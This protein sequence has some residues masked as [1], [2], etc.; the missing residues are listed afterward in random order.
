MF[1]VALSVT[2]PPPLTR[3]TS[4]LSHDDASDDTATSNPHWSVPPT[5]T[6]PEPVPS[7]SNVTAVGVGS[8]E[9]DVADCVTD[10]VLVPIVTV[11]IRSAPVFAVA[12]SV[13]VPP[14]ST[15]ATSALSHDAAPLD[16]DTAWLQWSEPPT[17]TPP[18]PVP[19][20]PNVTLVGV[21]PGAL[22]HAAADC[23]TDT[24]LVPIVTV[25]VRSPPVF[26]VA[27]SVT[28][29]PPSASVTSALSHD[30]PLDTDTA[31]LQWSEPPTSTPPSP[32][33]S[34][35]KVTDVGVKLGAAR[36]P[37]RRLRHRHRARADRHRP[38]ALA[39][40][41]RRHSSPIT[42]PPPDTDDEPTEIQSRLSLTLKLH[43]DEPPAV[44]DL[45]PEPLPKLRD[46]V[47]PDDEQPDDCVMLTLLPPIVTVPVRRGPSLAVTD[48]DTEPPPDTDDEPT[49]IQLRLSLT[50]KLHDD[51][52]PAVADLL[53]EPLPKLRDDVVPDDEQP[54]DCVML[55][56]L[57]PIVTV[58]VR[59]G[60]SLAVT[61]TDTEPPPDT[62]DEPTL[63]QLRLS[64]TL[65]LH[66]DE[67]PAV[68]DLL[69]E[70]LPK[71]RDDVVPD[72]EQPDDCVMLTLLP[73]IVTV[74]VRR[75][76][77]LAVTDTDTEPPPDTDDEPTLI[78]LRLSL[79]LKLHDDEP[80]AVADLLPEPLP[81]LRDDVVPDDEQPD[82][83]VMLT[84][85][86]PIVTVPVRRG[87]SLAVTDTD[88]EPPPDT[89]D[90]PTLIQLRLS[91][92]LKLH[93]DEPPAVA[94]LLPEPLP[95]LRDDVVPDDEQPDA[96]V[97]LTL[98]P[99]IVTVPVRRG[100]SLAVTDTDTDP[101]PD[102]D[103]EPTLIQLRLSLTLKLHLDKPFAVTDLLSEP[104]PKLSDVGLT[105]SGD[106]GH[107]AL[108]STE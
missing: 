64:L 97:M 38:R 27:L 42:E 90:E 23:V 8:A 77:S 31:W 100:P 99:P 14:P 91:L 16:T 67:P 17:S 53:P 52:P 49:L 73:P 72:D 40:G 108:C 15:E 35:A 30:D 54:D 62:D 58:P 85:L 5:A 59:R 84:L 69:P 19:S 20:A 41:I 7:A 11:P 104:L 94:D 29:S 25:P 60:P 36:T 13:T 95:K 103:D 88:T 105:E 50:L 68:A 1:A 70:P 47:V 55:T 56:L 12:L 45:L 78:Q 83:C 6:A 76:P 9:H 66:A 33:P 44:A 63:I 65:K 81:K 26:V 22:G 74:P 2:V 75:G 51:E 34:A 57:P 93:A 18:S 98:L 4:A 92:T 39:A 43:D 32:V 107:G 28:V 37:R 86:P 10:T 46:D 82:A 96:C 79:T 101:P 87:P 106:D 48:T 61:D 3:V 24:V 89:D 71:L 21:N 80:P 102:T